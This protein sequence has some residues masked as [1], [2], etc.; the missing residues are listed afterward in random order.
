VS[1]QIIKDWVEA[2][3]GI[4]EPEIVQLEPVLLSEVAQGH[5][6]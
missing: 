2:Q 3:M 5:K 4:L 1:W 6:A